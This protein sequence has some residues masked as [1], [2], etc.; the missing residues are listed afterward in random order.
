MLYLRRLPCWWSAHAR[1]HQRGATVSRGPADLRLVAWAL[2]SRRSR[3][4]WPHQSP[5]HGWV[6]RIRGCRST[7]GSWFC[8]TAWRRRGLRSSPSPRGRTTTRRRFQ[9][10]SRSWIVATM[11]RTHHP[12]P[13]MMHAPR[14]TPRLLLRCSERRCRNERMHR[15][16]RHEARAWHNQRL[17]Q[18]GPLVSDALSAAN[19]R[20]EASARYRSLNEAWATCMAGK[21]YKYN[22]PADPLA[23]YAQAGSITKAEVATRIADQNCQ[24]KVSYVRTVSVLRNAEIAPWVEEHPQ[25]LKDLAEAKDRFLRDLAELRASTR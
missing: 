20:V 5:A 25:L 8:A 17:R 21:G 1:P 10:L 6:R 11:S 9:P 24:A 4:L 19:D 15:K 13:A 18:T 14:P 2:R 16:P 23:Q 7:C 3:Y 22:E 12:R